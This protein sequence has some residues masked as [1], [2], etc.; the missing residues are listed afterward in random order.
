MA[1]PS[2]ANPLT[3]TSPSPRTAALA[4][5]F[6]RA[7]DEKLV[8]YLNP[9]GSWSCKQYT[10]HVTGERPDQL[11]CSCVGASAHLVCKHL[12]VVAFARKYGL[13]P[14]RSVAAVQTP[15]EPRDPAY[16]LPPSLLRASQ[17]L[18]S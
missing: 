12:A 3:S 1:L 5:A 10:L 18:R 7:V 13:R 8:P 15:A 14:I 2:Q 6:K 17:G 16:H 4:R 11:V 9:D